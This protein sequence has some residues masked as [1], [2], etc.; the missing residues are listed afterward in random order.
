MSKWGRDNTLT[1]TAGGEVPIK[2]S[3]KNQTRRQSAV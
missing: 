3:I 1:L 2:S